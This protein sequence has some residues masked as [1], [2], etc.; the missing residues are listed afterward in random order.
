MPVFVKED[1][2]GNAGLTAALVEDLA[3]MPLQR[4]GRDVEQVRDLG[5]AETF[6]QQLGNFMFGGGESAGRRDFGNS[7]LAGRIFKR[8]KGHS[9]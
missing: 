2:C 3:N 5:V 8:S 9:R 6:H 7:R 1:D 4:T